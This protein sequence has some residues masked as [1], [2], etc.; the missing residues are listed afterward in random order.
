MILQKFKSKMQKSKILAYKVLAKKRNLFLLF[1]FYF[2]LNYNANAQKPTPKTPSTNTDTIAK[3]K[4]LTIIHADKESYQKKD[5]I[6]LLSFVGHVQMK[7][8]KT[9]F[10][11]DS[12]SVNQKT[13]IVEAY[14]GVHINDNDSINIYSQYLKYNHLLKKA[15]LRNKVKLTDSK[16]IINT[17]E[18]DYDVNT[19]I[20]IY[21]HGGTVTNE[22]TI[23]TSEEA[24]YYGETK[25]ASFK[26]NVRL[27]H[28]EYKVFT[29]T[30]LY[31]TNTQIARFVAPTRIENGKRIIKTSDG[32]YDLQ[33]KT[34]QLGKRPQIIDT[35]YT[36]TANDMAFDDK[37]GV[38]QAKGNAVYKDTVQGISIIANTLF[39]NRTA[40]SSLAT[41]KPLMIIKQEKD[42]IYITGDTL[43]SGKITDFEK[44]NT[45]PSVRDSIHGSKPITL[46]AKDNSWNR[47]FM[48]FRHVKIF[49][50]SLQAICDSL[51]YSGRDSTLRLLKSPIVWSQSYQAKADTILAYLCK[52]KLER[53]YLF[54]NALIASQLD[55]SSNYYNQIKGNTINAFLKDGAMDYAR[56]KGNA[57]SVYYL[58]NDK[59]KY[60]GVNRASSD[61]IDL[62]F[63]ENKTDK[64]VFL[65]GLKGTTYPIL[66]VRQEDTILTGFK[67]YGELRPKTKFEL[68]GL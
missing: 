63:K 47:Y 15:N 10:Y 38:G 26:K 49:S 28:P 37:S 31:N 34:A 66:Q 8:E 17:N 13:N 39:V 7:Q 30:L 58:V 18:L 44:I 9:F 29:D 12:L 36:M 42:S 2:L 14:G 48:A 21:T 67:W 59:K 35:S 32:F 52:K 5:T 19:K 64:I 53:V 23:L 46:N 68:F 65:R 24:Y 3:N 6:E 11:C 55:S 22:K 4:Q 61:A 50:D 20:G 41:D 1:T 40:N 54:E 56:A 33:H 43:L 60:I 16:T 57:E 25:D 27:N 45:V 51:F 62:Y